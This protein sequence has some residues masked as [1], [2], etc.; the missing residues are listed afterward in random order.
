[1]GWYQARNGR[2]RPML[3]AALLEKSGIRRLATANGQ[4]AI[5][6]VGVGV[7]AIISGAAR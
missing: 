5:V 6:G 4:A 3:V 2:S 7:V 1:M